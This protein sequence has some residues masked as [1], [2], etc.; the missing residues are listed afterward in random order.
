MNLRGHLGDDFFIK[1]TIVGRLVAKNSDSLDASLLWVE[2][3]P[4]SLLGLDTHPLLSP[5]DSLFKF[6][7]FP[8]GHRGDT[9]GMTAY[10]QA[11]V[12]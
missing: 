8:L 12:G 11:R 5:A 3:H 1:L 2:V 9:F 7:L 4:L 10:D 6:L